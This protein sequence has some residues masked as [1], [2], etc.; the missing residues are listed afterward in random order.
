MQLF[1]FIG[2]GFGPSNLALA[3]AIQEETETKKLKSNTLFLEAKEQ[4]VWHPGMLL[5]NMS[6]QVSFLK[7]LATLRNPRS[8]FTFLNYLKESGSLDEFINLQEFFPT[9]IELNDYFTWAAKH[10]E[11]QVHYRKKVVD[12]RGLSLNQEKVID[13]LEV[14]ACDLDSGKTKSYYTQNL[15]VATGEDQKYQKARSSNQTEQFFIPHSFYL[16][17]RVNTII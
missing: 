9:R 1:D 7:D 17:Y 8:Y 6:T 12:L 13:V 16:A 15:V 5:E 4:F 3:V 11:N 2:I 10:F 14:I